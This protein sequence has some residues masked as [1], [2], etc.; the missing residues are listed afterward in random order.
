MWTL[1]QSA[2]EIICDAWN[3]PT[4]GSPLFQMVCSLKNTKLALKRWNKLVFGRVQANIIDTRAKIALIQAAPPTPDSLASDKSLQQLLDTLL[5]K[6]QHLW[7]DKAKEQWLEEGDQNSKFFHVS[8]LI[9]RRRNKIV[10]VQNRDHRVVSNFESIGQTFVEYYTDL[11]SSSN[12]YFPPELTAL[13]PT[14]LSEQEV[15]GLADVPLPAEIRS[16]VFSM[17]NGKSLG[18]DGMSPYFF[19]F[20]WEI[21]KD[22]TIKAVQYFFEHGFLIKPLNHTFVT[23]I[24]KRDNPH[25]VEHFRPISLCNVIYKIIS[26]ILANRLRPLLDQ[27]ISP[28]QSAFIPGRNMQDSVIV[29]HELMHHINRKKV[30]GHLMAVKI[31]LAKAY[32]KVEWSILRSIM[33]LHGIPAK[34]INLV[35]TCI[36][37]ASF[38]MMINGSPYGMFPSTRGLRQGDPL[39]P[40]LFTI[41]IDL[42][43]RLMIQAEATGYIQGIKVGRHC[44]RIS[45][46]LYADDATFFVK[47]DLVQA[48]RLRSLITNFCTWS[49]QTVNWGKSVIHFSKETPPALKRHICQLLCMTECSHKQLYLGHPFCKPVSKKIAFM[50]LLEKLKGRLAGWRGRLLS[51]A[52]RLTLIKS[53]ISSCPLH[54]MQVFLW[55]KQLTTKLDSLTR[56]FFWGFSSDCGRRLYLRSWSSICCPLTEGGLGLRK[57][58]TINLA[59]IAK[60]GWQILTRTPGIWVNLIRARYL[61]G[62]RSLDLHKCPPNASWIMQGIWK[63]R[64][65]ILQN[66]CIKLGSESTAPIFD[67]P[68]LPS[69]DGF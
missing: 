61:R 53:V 27:I 7:G 11:F 13:F 67:S 30:N 64:S 49:G 31:D 56:D 16:A 58:H 38:S 3:L 8:T 40:A 4:E 17:S 2:T 6:E 36:S 41:F 57:F 1:E 28:F 37:T 22:R 51:Q 26:K 48:D 12:P 5:L 14:P 9:R 39:S 69:L 68:W 33:Q 42:L 43:S 47:A 59:F 50:E 21:L 52:G 32:D 18:S 65:L 55:P 35:M 46:L 24:P 25:L 34:F 54:S 63:S 44:S 15:H 60:L 19:K 45:H 29:C 20:Y 62:R 66:L 10:S 23:L